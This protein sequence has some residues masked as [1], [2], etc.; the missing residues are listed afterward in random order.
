MGIIRNNVNVGSKRSKKSRTSYKYIPRFTAA[1]SDRFFF[2]YYLLSVPCIVARIRDALTKYSGSTK[3][4][5]FG[6]RVKVGPIRDLAQARN[7][8]S[9]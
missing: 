4:K 9:R 7:L 5:K 1:T 2:I 3:Y 6:H 8:S